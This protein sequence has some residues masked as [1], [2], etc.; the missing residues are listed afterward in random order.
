VWTNQQTDKQKTPDALPVPTD[1]VSMGMT[2]D[3]SD[4]LIFICVI[5]TAQITGL[6]NFASADAA[7]LAKRQLQL[8]REM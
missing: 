7:L 6:I 1:T 2:I 8:N 4:R 5:M 3:Q